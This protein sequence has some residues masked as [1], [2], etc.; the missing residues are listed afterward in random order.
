MDDIQELY[1]TFQI[2]E[3]SWIRSLPQ[4]SQQQQRQGSPTRLEDCSL[5]Y[6]EFAFVLAGLKP[7]ILIQLPTPEMT[8]AYYHNALVP[9]LIHHPAFKRQA[10]APG[11]ELSCQLITRNVHSPEMHLQGYVLLWSART[12][13][14]HPQSKH[15][16][17]GINLLCHPNALGSSDMNESSNNGNKP[18]TISEEDLALMLDI[19][20]RLPETEMELK[21]MIEVSYWSQG[22]CSTD[23]EPNEPLL[24]TAFAAQPDQLSDIQAH[25][26]RYKDA[27]R[28]LYRFQLKLHVQSMSDMQ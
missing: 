7:C 9:H 14:A 13:Q 16:Q 15:I 28:D 18:A 17:N 12:V 11:L 23:K 10:K 3:R 1:S 22:H 24:L 25:F 6:G 5:H 2:A 21:R 4:I 20:G 8:T 27:V 26:K 19:P